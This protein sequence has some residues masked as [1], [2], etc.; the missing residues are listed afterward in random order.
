[1]PIAGV[2]YLLLLELFMTPLLNHFAFLSVAFGAFASCVGGG[3]SYKD[4]LSLSDHDNSDGIHVADCWIGL[5]EQ[6]QVICKLSQNIEDVV[7]DSNTEFASAIN[8]DFNDSGNYHQSL[9]ITSSDPVW[10]QYSG[11]VSL[12]FLNPNKNFCEGLGFGCIYPYPVTIGFNGLDENT[13][14][15]PSNFTIDF[16][17]TLDH[18]SLKPLRIVYIP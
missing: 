8:F 14:Q 2:A 15:V 9:S 18:S 17:L 5:Q 1:M 16:E 4:D 7:K 10:H 6:Q 12:E 11:V 3:D 13:L